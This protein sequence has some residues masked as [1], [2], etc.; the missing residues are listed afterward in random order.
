[1]GFLRGDGTSF[2]SGLSV[3]ECPLLDGAQ[4]PEALFVI[5][6]IE[7]QAAIEPPVPVLDLNDR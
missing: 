7:G 2:T 4:G 3:N 1:M 6:P 5:V